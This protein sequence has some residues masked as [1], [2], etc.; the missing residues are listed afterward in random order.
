MYGVETVSG[1]VIGVVVSTQV[2]S[3][4]LPGQSLS[5]EPLVPDFLNGVNLQTVTFVPSSGN[6]DLALADPVRAHWSRLFV[7]GFK[8]ALN[9]GTPRQI[10]T[11]P[12]CV[13]VADASCDCSCRL[14]IEVIDDCRGTVVL[15]AMHGGR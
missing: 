8:A 12:V 3:A 7:I 14:R 10:A 4:W 5:P 15:H 2:L 9:N 1:Y 13:R 11:V 6:L